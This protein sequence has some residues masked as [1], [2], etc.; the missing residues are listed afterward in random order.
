MTSKGKNVF[1]LGAPPTPIA[2][3]SKVRKDGRNFINKQLADMVQRAVTKKPTDG[4][5]AFIDDNDGN[6]N[7]GTDFTDERHLSLLAIERMI[8]KLD[9]IFPPEQK[10]KNAT[11]NGHA[12][13]KPYQGCYGTYPVGCGYCTGYNHTE[14]ACVVKNG[15]EKRPRST[16]S[17]NQE[18]HQQNKSVKTT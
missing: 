15:K 13:C 8:G 5:A 18:A 12:T 2:I 17:E 4:M 6:F 9:E 1:I 11:L 3:S 10:L 16:G 7:P 14:Q